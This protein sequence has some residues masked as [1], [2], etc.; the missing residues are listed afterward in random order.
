MTHD[1]LSEAEHVKLVGSALEDYAYNHA[2]DT[3]QWLL[4]NGG[5]IEMVLS[6][7]HKFRIPPPTRLSAEDL[8]QKGLKFGFIDD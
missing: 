4:G 8:K 6:C 7:G 5:P 2:G 1:S 3:R